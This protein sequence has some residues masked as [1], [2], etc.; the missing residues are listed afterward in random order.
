MTGTN[1][2]CQGDNN[3]AGQHRHVPVDGDAVWYKYQSRQTHGMG[4][5]SGV[6]YGQPGPVPFH[7]QE[8][9]GSTEQAQMQ[10]QERLSTYRQPGNGGSPFRGR[11]G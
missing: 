8:V 2:D 5:N 9:R 7:Q 11:S 1:L 3:G 6:D 4:G 10:E